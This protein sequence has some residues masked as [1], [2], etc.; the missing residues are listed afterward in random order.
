[1]HIHKSKVADSV[2]G[3]VQYHRLGHSLGGKYK[4]GLKEKQKSNVWCFEAFC[5]N[6]FSSNT[7]FKIERSVCA[8]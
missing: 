4:V 1:M 2:F 8:S 3:S 6:L 5:W 7:N